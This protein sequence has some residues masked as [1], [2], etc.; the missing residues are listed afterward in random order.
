MKVK[1]QPGLRKA[2]PQVE[3]P[4]PIRPLC[5]RVFLTAGGAIGCPKNFGGECATL[6]GN[7]C[8]VLSP[9][10]YANRRPVGR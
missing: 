5:P 8:P 10:V 1:P 9:V 3:P 2:E 6:Y 4:P 7:P